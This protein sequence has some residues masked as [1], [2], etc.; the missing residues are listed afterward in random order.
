[1]SPLGIP[2]P[3]EIVQKESISQVRF[4]RSVSIKDKPLK[5]LLAKVVG[6]AVILPQLPAISLPQL[7]CL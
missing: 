6:S 1:M 5:L 3:H 4:H 7:T 2:I